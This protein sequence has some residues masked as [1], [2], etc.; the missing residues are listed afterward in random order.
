MLEEYDSY[1]SFINNKNLISLS[2]EQSRLMERRICELHELCD[3][4]ISRVDTLFEGEADI[5]SL[6]SILSEEDIISRGHIH[7]EV[8]E[9]N[10][11]CLEKHLNSLMVNDKS[12]L[13]QML[14]ERLGSIGR[15]PK[16]SDFLKEMPIK[17]TLCYVKNPLSDEAYDVFS[18][19]FNDPHLVYVNTLRDAARSVIDGAVGFCLLPLEESGGVR[20]H[21]VEELIYKNDLKISALT[22][23]FG[24]DGTAG[25]KYALV[26]R[27]FKHEPHTDTDDRYLEIRLPTNDNISL[28]ELLSVSEFY[29][30]SL[31]RV[32]TTIFDNDDGSTNEFYSIV[33]RNDGCDFTLLLLYLTLFTDSFNA[34]GIYKNLE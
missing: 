20:I 12:I 31:Y 18:E 13:C 22:P 3:F 1:A 15:P 30:H 24:F 34:V 6:L 23:V 33:F 9:S 7:N 21:T 2:K 10:T 28:A 19:Q 32:N 14:N 8:L 17:E 4:M 16:E 26:S 11:V 29:G 27:Y 25:M 5:Y